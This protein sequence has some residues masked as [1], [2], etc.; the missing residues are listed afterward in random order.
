[1]FWQE[2]DC[3]YRHAGDL[4]QLDI[5]KGQVT[6]MEMTSCLI[7][8]DGLSMMRGKLKTGFL[9]TLRFVYE[10]LDDPI[11]VLGFWDAHN[12]T[13]GK[14]RCCSGSRSSRTLP[15]KV[16]SRICTFAELVFHPRSPGTVDQRSGLGGRGNAGKLR[17]WRRPFVQHS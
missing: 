13:V 10:L 12:D 7:Q 14:T 8:H 2:A 11:D 6:E 16:C 17:K 4:V 5:C 15:A 1:M 3:F 9:H